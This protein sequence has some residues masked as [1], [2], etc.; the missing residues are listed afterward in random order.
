M[1]GPESMTPLKSLARR[2]RELSGDSED[3]LFELHDFSPNSATIMNPA[4]H[5]RS[6]GD[7]WRRPEQLDYYVDR[8][9]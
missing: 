1:A 5:V 8:L 9:R 7:Y 4:L 2:V 6:H 3:F